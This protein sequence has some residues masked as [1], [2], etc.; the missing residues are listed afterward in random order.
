MPEYF[1]NHFPESMLSRFYTFSTACADRIQ[2][3]QLS[4]NSPFCQLEA[5]LD[6]QK[7]DEIPSS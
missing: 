1:R 4:N 5:Q 6:D 3:N 2:I 7:Q